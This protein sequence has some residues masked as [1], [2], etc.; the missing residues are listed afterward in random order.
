MLRLVFKLVRFGIVGVAATGVHAGVVVGLVEFAGVYPLCAN[1]FAYFC[2]V[3][4]SFS[5]HLYWT[6]RAQDRKSFRMFGRFLVV[7]VSGFGLSQA[8]FWVLF[9]VAGVDYRA[10]LAAVVLTVPTFTFLTSQFWVFAYE[11]TR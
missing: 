1:V 2:A 11:R 3:A 7:S 4:V 8:L 6:F 9:E 5:G 10:T